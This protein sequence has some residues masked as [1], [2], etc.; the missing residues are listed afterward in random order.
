MARVEAR[1]P[2]KLPDSIFKPRVKECD[3]KAFWDSDDCMDKMFER[4]W[5]RASAK[6]KFTGGADGL[7]K[8]HLLL[9]PIYTDS[10]C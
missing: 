7:L 2:W 3:S 5:I 8:N 4:D 1:E 6:E 9:L 10:K